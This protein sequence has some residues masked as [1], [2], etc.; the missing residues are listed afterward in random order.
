MN[1]TGDCTILLDKLVELIDQNFLEELINKYNADYKVH[2]LTTK[3]HLLYL[4]YFHLT[5]KDSLEDFVSDLKHNKQLNEALP[6]ISKS[7]LSRTNKSRS[8]LLFLEIFNHLFNKLKSSVGLKK[9]LKGIGPVKLLD[10]SI[11]SLCLSAFPWAKFRKTKGGIKLHTLYD[12]NAQAPENVIVTEALIHDKEIFDNLSWNPD[13]TYVFD[14]AY[15]DYKKFDEF[16]EKGIC[17]VTRTKANTQ[18]EIARSLPLTNKDKEAGILKDADIFLGN[19]VSNTKMKNQMRLVRV[20]TTDRN[21]KEKII[22]ILTNRFDL[23]AY[24]I[25]QLYKNRWQIELFFK[26]I[27]Q[28]LK[29]KKFFGQNKNAVLIQIYTALILFLLLRLIKRKAKFSGSMLELTRKIKYS[30]KMKI[31]SRFSLI[32]W[33]TES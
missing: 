21:G 17:F 19:E 32:P 20:K 2:K 22:D 4:L 7:Q 16:T 29:I 3:T 11:I 9:S 27:K 25:A 28:H 10:S 33:L 12:L 18:I 6:E 15:I 5:E 23:P 26:W 30:I 8:Y 13:C 24:M 31:T 14:R 1:S